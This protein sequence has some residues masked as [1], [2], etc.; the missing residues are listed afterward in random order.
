MTTNLAEVLGA[1]PEDLDSPLP[2]P[3][4][5]ELLAHIGSRPLPVGRLSRFWTL[6]TLQG[7]I[8]AAY[9]F[10]WLR[11]LWQDADARQRSLNETNLKAAVR[12]LGTMSYLRGAVMKLGQML[13]H[14]PG[15]APDEF[16]DMLGRLHFQAPPMHY[17]LI[18]EHLTS[19]LG[20][21]PQS[22]FDSFQTEASAAASLGQVHRARLKEG[23]AVAIK[24][25][26]PGIAR[27]IRSDIATLKTLVSPMRLGTDGANIIEQLDDI[28]QMLALETDYKAEAEN[29]RF[30]ARTVAGI[31]GVAIPAVHDQYTTQ[32][33]LTMDWLD[34]LHLDQY[35]ATRPSQEERD[36]MGGLLVRG[37]MRL[38]YTGHM[39]HADPAPG[40]F[41]FLKDGRL[42]IIDFGCVRRYTPDDVDYLNE[43]ET[44]AFISRDAIR[45]VLIRGADLTP[46]QQ[47]D[48]DRIAL[49]ESWYD[50][51]CEPILTEEPFDF[52]DESYIRRGMDIWGQLMRRRY[53]RS[54][55]VNT[56]LARSFVGTRAMLYRL[57]ARVPF[58]R[59]AREETSVKRPEAA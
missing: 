41:L 36:R 42:G 55:P 27:A 14:W 3:A 57:G 4:L 43:G 8:A 10:W 5:T 38:C 39:L 25:Q 2:Q 24:V 54:L 17:S 53:I 29:L 19:E 28:E 6:G 33:V 11:A 7:K 9:T 16:A 22:L 26:Y 20:A 31:D 32:R 48:K 37:T 44:A 21:D 56:W 1:L 30:A 49:L 12:L 40:N 34:G 15:V 23:T 46:R 51:T 45:K 58:G 47:T 50:W 18:R 35:L 59:I 13:A 52:G